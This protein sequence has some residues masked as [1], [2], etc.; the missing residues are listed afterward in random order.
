MVANCLQLYANIVQ[1][2]KITK[3]FE[4]ELLFFCLISESLLALNMSTAS[5]YNVSAPTEYVVLSGDIDVWYSLP[6][7]AFHPEGFI[8]LL[9]V[10]NIAT[11]SLNINI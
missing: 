9:E 4:T 11:V 6:Q 5:L 1:Q 8:R 7:D 10:N 2:R 3:E